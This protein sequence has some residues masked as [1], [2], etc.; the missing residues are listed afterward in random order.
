MAVWCQLAGS[1]AGEAAARAILGW[2]AVARGSET[3]VRVGWVR[4]KV[5]RAWEG[6][7]EY[8]EEL[9]QRVEPGP[10]KPSGWC[11]PAQTGGGCV[12]GGG[13]VPGNRPALTIAGAGS[14]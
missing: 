7:L 12:G 2:V 5:W 14:S 8:G 6:A 9:C 10:G 13:P 1:V 4:D 3:D 11:L